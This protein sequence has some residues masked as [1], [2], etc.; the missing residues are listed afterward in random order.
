MSVSKQK[1]LDHAKLYGQSYALTL[2]RDYVENP[3]WF[4][5]GL[6][7]LIGFDGICGASLYADC[8]WEPSDEE[9]EIAKN[10]MRGIIQLAIDVANRYKEIK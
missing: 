10:S 4:P 6:N 9:E 2:L 8:S 7:S 5:K 1:R 3:A